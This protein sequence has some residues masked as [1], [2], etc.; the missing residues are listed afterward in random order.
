MALVTGDLVGFS[1]PEKDSNKER[2]VI[3]WVKEREDCWSVVDVQRVVDRLIMVL[4][5]SNLELR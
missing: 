4:S 5:N 1:I 2:W 3:V